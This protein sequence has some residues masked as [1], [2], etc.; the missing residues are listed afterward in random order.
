METI[1]YNG[2]KYNA[3]HSIDVKDTLVAEEMLTISLNH[4]PFTVTMRTPGNDKELALGLTFTEGVYALDEPL[5]E[6]QITSL[7]ERN[8]P[9]TIQVLTHKQQLSLPT[10]Q[11]SMLSVSSCG[12]CGK[13]QIDSLADGKIP[14]THTDCILPQNIE[15]MFHAMNERQAT[16]QQ[17]GG[18]HAAAAFTLDAKLL[19]V[20]EDI[21]RH[22]AVDKVIGELI[23]TNQLTQARCLVV[24]GRVSFEIVSKCHA[25]G[26]PFLSAVSAPSSLAVDISDKLGITL[27]AFCRDQS[28]T[29]YSHPSYIHLDHTTIKK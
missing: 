17:S 3:G 19:S 13:T 6:M 22:N 24:S 28:F 8:I 20:Q 16:F 4:Q 23:L 14:I 5:P 12:I 26:I 10:Q 1:R 2:I 15:S 11:R 7:N 18:S 29:I 9:L 25:A 21:G 27:M